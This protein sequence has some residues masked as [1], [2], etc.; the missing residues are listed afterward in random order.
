[1]KV[2]VTY[3]NNNTVVYNADDMEIK[4]NFL[5]LYEEKNPHGIADDYTV[6]TI[7]LVNIQTFIV[8]CDRYMIRD[9]E[10]ETR[11]CTAATKKE[12]IE[13]IRKLEF[14]D[15]MN[16]IYEPGFYEYIKEGE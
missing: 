14:E 6:S 7:P 2:E 5:I 15:E 12:A 13:T 8:D 4:N 16:N 10:T 3:R 11:I 1:M 9:R